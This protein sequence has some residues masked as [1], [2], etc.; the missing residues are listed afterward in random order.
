MLTVN[1][2]GEARFLAVYPRPGVNELVFFHQSRIFWKHR[3]EIA[4][5]EASTGSLEDGGNSGQL[6]RATRRLAGKGVEM[7]IDQTDAR[8]LI[9]IG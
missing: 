2:P 6:L 8:T 4:C 3:V 7:Y 1:P 9:Y 5:N